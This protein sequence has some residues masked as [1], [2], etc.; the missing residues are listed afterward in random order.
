MSWHHY[1]CTAASV[2]R[3][4]S[5]G[6][7]DLAQHVHEREY[8]RCGCYFGAPHRALLVVI[9]D[10]LRAAVAPGNRRESAPQ[11]SAAQ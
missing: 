2:S 3:P 7:R 4:Q 10:A 11:E 1:I 6:G 5:I 9:A 8:V